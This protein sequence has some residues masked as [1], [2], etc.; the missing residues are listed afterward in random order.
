MALV[1]RGRDGHAPICLSPF[2]R[3]GRHGLITGD[4]AR[5]RLTIRDGIAELARVRITA[6]RPITV[7]LGRKGGARK[8]G[9]AH[10]L[11]YGPAAP[12]SVHAA[13]S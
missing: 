11:Y 5:G 13:R 3:T 8:P 2:F 6:L 4:A 7:I 12:P 1:Y 9:V 10:T